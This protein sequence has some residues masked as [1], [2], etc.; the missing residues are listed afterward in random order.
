[1]YASPAAHLRSPAPR[2][3]Y[4]VDGS[5]PGKQQDPIA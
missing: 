4:V 2:L 3:V 5:A 1:M